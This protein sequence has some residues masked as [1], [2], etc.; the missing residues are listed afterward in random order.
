[1]RQ[2]RYLCAALGMSLS[3]FFS[4]AQAQ[5]KMWV[6]TLQAPALSAQ[7]TA[8][9]V[10]LAAD[11]PKVVDGTITRVQLSLRYAGAAILK[12]RLC[13]PFS[14]ICVDLQGA[15]LNSAAFAGLR[16]D[17]TFSLH[18]QVWSWAGPSYPLSM[19]VRLHVQYQESGS[20]PAL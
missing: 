9:T 15:T 10:M 16:A 2:M 18:Y 5:E 12:S 3:V 20:L 8:S 19:Q 11:T 6:Q 17:S 4:A 1:M 13:H 7:K 14:G